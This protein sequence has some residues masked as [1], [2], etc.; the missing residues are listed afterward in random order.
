MGGT[1]SPPF[2]PGRLRRHAAAADVALVVVVVVDLVD[3]VVAVA[4]APAPAA[5]DNPHHF[6]VVTVGQWILEEARVLQL[7]IEFAGAPTD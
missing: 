6:A 1:P 2:R 5:V 4:A 3:I 7:A